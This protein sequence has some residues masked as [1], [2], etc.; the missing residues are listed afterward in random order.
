MTHLCLGALLGVRKLEAS[1]LRV[2]GSNSLAFREAGMRDLWQGHAHPLQRPQESQKELSLWFQGVF[3]P[4][5]MLLQGKK[6]Y[7]E[8][9]EWP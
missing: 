6:V 9:D 3:G 4:Q 7:T 2:A 1:L 8:G 5:R